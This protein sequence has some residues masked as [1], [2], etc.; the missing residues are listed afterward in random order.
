[1][2]QHSA[3]MPL[4][5]LGRRSQSLELC[6]YYN[7]TT[8]IIPTVA[9]TFPVTAACVIKICELCYNCMIIHI[10]Q[11]MLANDLADDILEIKIRQKTCRIHK[12][13]DSWQSAGHQNCQSRQAWLSPP[14]AKQFCQHLHWPLAADCVLTTPANNTTWKYTDTKLNWS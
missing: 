5:W 7:I 9:E 3:W 6:C 11:C 12:S 4:P 1:M 13:I 14:A 8:I 2:N 10:C